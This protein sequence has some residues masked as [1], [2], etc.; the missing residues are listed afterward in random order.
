ML[1]LVNEERWEIYF[2]TQ[3]LI[4]TFFMFVFFLQYYLR[5]FFPIFWLNQ[6]KKVGSFVKNKPNFKFEC[7]Y[8]VQI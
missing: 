1:H 2:F 4:I 5:C 7:K 3:K 8:I 6:Y